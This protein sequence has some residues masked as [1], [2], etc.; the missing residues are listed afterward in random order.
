MF[1]DLNQ[2]IPSSSLK[3]GG[4]VIVMEKLIVILFTVIFSSNVFAEI[5]AC[6]DNFNK[7]YFR[8]DLFGI[9]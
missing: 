2:I 5:V 6:K 7:I 9:K 3:I 1:F 4:R 8:Y